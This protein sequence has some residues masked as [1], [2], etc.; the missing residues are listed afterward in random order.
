MSM[1]TES[2]SAEVAVRMFAFYKRKA[3]HGEEG[4]HE[5]IFP[6]FILTKQE[7][8]ENTSTP[9]FEED[10]NVSETAL[11]LTMLHPE[12]KR[13]LSP[14]GQNSVKTFVLNR[15]LLDEVNRRAVW[16]IKAHPWVEEKQKDLGKSFLTEIPGENHPYFTVKIDCIGAFYFPTG[17]TAV[18]IDILPAFAVTDTSAPLIGKMLANTFN[19]GHLLEEQS[20]GKSG[21]ILRR[22][23]D[24]DHTEEKLQSVK[25]R[26]GENRDS[27]LMKGLLGEETTLNSI[28]SSLLGK[29]YELLMG[30]RFISCVFLKTKWE[31]T[32]RPFHDSDY[33]DLVRMSRSQNDKYIPYA[34]DCK[35]GGRH[36]I[37]TFEN[38]I[39]SLS[40]EGI[41]CWI[42]PQQ[43]Q[44][45]LE[46]QFKQRFHGIYQQLI[47]L[48]LHQRYALVALAQQLSQIEFPHVDSTPEILRDRS[49]ILRKQR[50]EVADF[51]L[52]AYFRQPA[53]LD[54]HQMFYQKLQDALGI[55]SLLE[56]V[57]KSTKELDHIITSTYLHEQNSQSIQILKNIEKLTEKQEHSAQIEQT[58]TYVVEVTALPYYTY[59]ITKAFFKLFCVSPHS[60]VTE[61][62][63]WPEWLAIFVAFIATGCAVSMTFVKNKRMKHREKK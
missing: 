33:I 52:R 37:N 32:P 18:Y 55:A 11:G 43:K 40:G 48:A 28:L 35:P 26:F 2:V 50:K 8:G 21:V 16:K 46:E 34:E 57:Q 15:L 38:V 45:F 9:Y 5:N 31:N 3:T 36:I 20:E 39:F 49:I 44:T 59:G 19:H 56:E 58:L 14:S 54:N 29:G 10:K 1:I 6:C 51:Y 30:D 17:V 60:G 25:N 53:V 7:T 42:K 12:A 23:F 27:G 22:I 4:K 41:A 24:K 61:L 13:F 62:P 63:K 47:L